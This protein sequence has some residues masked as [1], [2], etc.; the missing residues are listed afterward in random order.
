MKFDLGTKFL[1]QLRKLKAMFLTDQEKDDGWFED[2][3]KVCDGMFQQFKEEYAVMLSYVD[4]VTVEGVC[5]N[6][7]YYCK[8]VL[9]HICKAF[10]I[11]VKPSCFGAR[12]AAT[13]VLI[14]L[15]G[16]TEFD[17]PELMVI[18]HFVFELLFS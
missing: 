17:L 16:R 10:R 2:V 11:I 18:H 14:D 15:F 5:S 6:V 3:Q 9:F 8:Y 12:V 1:P 13:Q 7:G 4:S